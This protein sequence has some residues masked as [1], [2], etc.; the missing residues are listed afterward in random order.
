MQSRAW[1][2][3]PIL[4]EEPMRD[5]S[6]F[7]VDVSKDWIDIARHG[8]NDTRRI[9]NT[10]AAISAWISGLP[11]P[12]AALICFEPTGGYER[13][14]QRCLRRAGQRFARASQPGQPVSQGQRR[15][16]QN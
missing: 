2:N 16:S 9:D 12:P 8:D 10:E 14:L 5:K 4:M 11:P 7:G 13:V 3:T 1:T 6:F 15:Q